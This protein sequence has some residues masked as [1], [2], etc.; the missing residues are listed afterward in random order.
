M[1]SLLFWLN[2]EIIRSEAV[3]KRVRT[4][5][6]HSA[7]PRPDGNPVPHIE[8]A[9]LLEM[10]FL[11]ACFAET[12]RLRTHIL[13]TR[14][15][16][17]HDMMINEWRLP[18]KNLIMTCPTVPHMDQKLWNTRLSGTQPLE[19]FWPPR[20]LKNPDD[21][22]DMA[23]LERDITESSAQPR[24]GSDI[25]SSDDPAI[26]AA[27]PQ[28]STNG[29]EGIWIPFGGGGQMCP[30][31]KLAKAEIFHVTALLVTRFDIELC[32]PEK[33]APMDWSYFGTGVLKPA[34]KVRFWIR[35]RVS[36]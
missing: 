17:T 33:E 36:A 34:A 6:L 29:L 4:E 35:K 21:Y 12:L 31:R 9:F 27:Q 2:Y 25:K 7:S 20:F 23:A 15:P 13:I 8:L 26:C 5:C 18:A 32:H 28:F 10:P 30:G 1:I 16:D 11:Q 22:H 3:L 24:V 14:Y 19:T